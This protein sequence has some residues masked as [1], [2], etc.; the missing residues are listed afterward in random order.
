VLSHASRAWADGDAIYAFLY[1]SH[2]YPALLD[3]PGS[4][5]QMLTIGCRVLLQSAA[6][7]GWSCIAGVGLGALSRRTLWVTGTLF[8]LVVLGATVGTTTAARANAFNAEVFAVM[9]YRVVFPWLLRIVLVLLP[10]VWGMRRGYRRPALHWRATLVM[11]AVLSV[12]TVSTGPAIASA[13]TAG[14]IRIPSSPPPIDTDAVAAH[15]QAD[16]ARSP[17]AAR[18]AAPDFVLRDVNG[19]AVK[20][21]DY[22]GK[23]VLLD[24]WATWCGGCKVEIPWFREF[25]KTYRDRGLVSIG[26]AVDDDGWHTV[27]PFLQDHPISYRI[28]ISDPDIIQRY[29]ITNLPVTLLIDRDGRIADSHLGIVEKQAWEA[30]IQ[31]LLAESATP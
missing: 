18:A 8:C 30:E 12:L 20:L 22:R 27:K 21:S 4:R 29:H 5:G 13:M 15:V 10:A 17:R 25:D 31:T 6:L 3:S 1:V 7:I 11:A 19:V 9:L 14:R 16:A 28:V 2:W 23:V 24:F 26:V